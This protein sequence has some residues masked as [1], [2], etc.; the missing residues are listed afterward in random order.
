MFTFLGPSGSAT[1]G[2]QFMGQTLKVNRPSGY[3]PMSHPGAGAVPVSSLNQKPSNLLQVNN[4]PQ[5]LTEEQ[6]KQLL[7]PFGSIKFFSLP[8]DSGG[9]SM[10]SAIVEYEEEAI[11][12]VVLQ[13][14]STIDVAG[15]KLNVV[16][17][18]P[19]MRAALGIPADISSNQG[20]AGEEVTV[21]TVLCLKNMLTE[22]ELKDDE[23][24]GEIKEEMM[25]EC[26]KHGKIKSMEIPRPSSDATEVAG[27]SN[28]YV[29]YEEDSSASA[30]YA[31]LQGRSF[32]GNVVECSYIDVEK[33]HNKDFSV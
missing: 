10:G 9:L 16:R 2:L 3:Q 17:V 25:E 7:E 22:D 28:V 31:V 14:L 32:G 27:L 12:S 30:A 21:T 4:L 8:K 19:S 20:A 11:A 6:V 1:G 26:G 24:F 5:S 13:S 15:S 29:E 23:E 33:Y 18:P